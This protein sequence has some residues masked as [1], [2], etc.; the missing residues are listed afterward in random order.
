[1]IPVLLSCRFQYRS[2]N[3]ILF[4]INIENIKIMRLF[5]N[6][7]MKTAVSVSNSVANESTQ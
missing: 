2:L 4:K 5:S 7:K 6:I 3:A 1:M